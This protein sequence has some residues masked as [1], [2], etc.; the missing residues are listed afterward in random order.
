MTRVART[1]GLALACLAGA[2]LPAG[3]D[4]SRQDDCG[5]EPPGRHDPAPPVPEKAGAVSR[6]VTPAGPFLRRVRPRAATP[7]LGP[8]GNHSEGVLSGKTVYVS[9]GHGFLWTPQSGWYTQRA[10]TNNLIEDLISAEGVNQYVLTYLRNMGA[11]VVP[12]RESDPNPEMVIVDDDE[13]TTEGSVDDAGTEN[14]YN[15]K[16][17]PNSDENVA[18]FQTGTSQKL[19]ANSH[20]TKRI[21]YASSNP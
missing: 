3:A 8:T 13:A 18:Q 11:F 1:L 16:S 21:I 2:T 12:L 19:F 14:S 7:R 9:P 5:L 6:T 10:N 20:E 15:T 4:V 17:Y